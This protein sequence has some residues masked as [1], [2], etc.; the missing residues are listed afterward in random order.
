MD[1]RNKMIIAAL[2]IIALGLA[3]LFFLPGG[4][5]YPASFT[6]S[7]GTYN[8]TAYAYTT[9]QQEKGLMNATVTNSTIMLFGF[10]KP[11]LYSFWMKDTYSP[12]DIIWVNY[13][14]LQD[15]GTVVYI[16]NAIPCASY[17]ANQSDCTIYTPASDANYVIEAR[18]GFA[19]ASGIHVGSNLAFN[20]NSR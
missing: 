3:A 17:S 4:N 5:A 18:S 16:V 11:G 20:H 9:A 1:G 2:I 10:P 8:I 6:V 14:A 13:S 19:N 15:S 7:G 12:L